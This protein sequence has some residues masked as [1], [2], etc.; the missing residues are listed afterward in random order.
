M[1]DFCGITSTPSQL[2]PLSIKLDACHDDI[3]PFSL[4][5]KA[6]FSLRGLEVDLSRLGPG[7]GM[8]TLLHHLAYAHLTLTDLNI[9]EHDAFQTVRNP[10][11]DFASFVLYIAFGCPLL[12]GSTPRQTSMASC[13]VW[14]TAF[15]PS[16]RFCLVLCHLCVSTSWR[17]RAS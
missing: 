16:S 3:I 1:I 17:A 11:R 8:S 9:N 5:R 15:L 6:D 2:T 7:D 10:R 14:Q 13:G 4:R 12:S